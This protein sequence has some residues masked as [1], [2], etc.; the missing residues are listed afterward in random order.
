LARIL[1]VDDSKVML[2]AA[3]KLLGTEF[4]VVT[5][6]DGEDAWAKLE[7][8]PTIQVLFTDLN[9]PRCDGFELLR[10]V[11]QATEP[12]LQSMPVIVVTGTSDDESA[13]VKALDMG[14]TDFITK[15][16]ASTDLTARARAHAKYQR[17][18]QQL[19][20]QSMLDPLTG[21]ASKPGFLDRLQQDIAYARR[22]QQ[23]LTLV[24]LEIDDLRTIFLKRGKALAERLVMDVS[25]LI[26]AR[27]RKE[28]TAGRIGLGSFAIS[29]PGGKAAGIEGLIAR[30]HS[31]VAAN[32]RQVEGKPLPIMLHAAMLSAELEDWPSAQEAIERCQVLLDSARARAP[33]PAPPAPHPLSPSPSAA[34]ALPQATR[35]RAEPTTQR[36]ASGATNEPL[37]LDPLLAQVERGQTQEAIARMTDVIRR[38]VPLLRLLDASQGAMLIRFLE[39]QRAG[40]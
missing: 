10:R 24:R 35:E 6:V 23:A 22:H 39:K 26:R 30:L 33:A 21:L 29:L 18:T 9:M 28:D 7:H 32:P 12:G 15:P 19:Q 27:I 16:F 1:V 14:A 11:R 25:E 34:A 20:A 37:L 36:H 17:I 5:A 3:T 2:K 8:D 13:R 40:A 4:E 31:E 38:L